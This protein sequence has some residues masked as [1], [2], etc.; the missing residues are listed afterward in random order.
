MLS[1]ASTPGAA[2]LLRLVS[3][4][5]AGRTRRI[6]SLLMLNGSARNEVRWSEIGYVMDSQMSSGSVAN[7]KG[8]RILESPLKHC[9]SAQRATTGQPG[10]T[11]QVF[12]QQCVLP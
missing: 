10:A 8:P 7:H 6:L 4:G 1:I 3:F 9:D 2:N 5:G 12:R 11:P